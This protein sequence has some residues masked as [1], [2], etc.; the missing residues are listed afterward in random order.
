MTQTTTPK[1]TSAAIK[2]PSGAILT[3]K[4]HSNIIFEASKLGWKSHN[5]KQ[6]FIVDCDRFVDRIEAM[7][8]AKKSGQIKDPDELMGPELYSEDLW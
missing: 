4:R 6:G 1:I 5:V 3:G 2:Y 7:E 8:L